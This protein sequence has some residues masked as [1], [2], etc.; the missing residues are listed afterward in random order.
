MVVHAGAVHLSKDFI[1]ADQGFRH[2]GYVVRPQADGWTQPLSGVWLSS[3]WQD[4]GLIQFLP[5]SPMPFVP[6]DIIGILPI[7]SCLAADAMG[8]CMTLTGKIVP[9]F[10]KSAC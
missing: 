7:H 6:G 8:G 5:E 4:H 1:A 10:R 3:V 2:Y 9:M